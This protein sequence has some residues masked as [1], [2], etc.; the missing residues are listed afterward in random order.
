MDS[1]TDPATHRVVIHNDNQHSFPYVINVLSKTLAI[2]RTAA[3]QMAEEIHTKG[4]AAIPVDTLA[5]AEALRKKIFAY[6]RDALAPHSNGSLIVGIESRNDAGG[7]AVVSC[8]RVTTEGFIEMNSEAI[9]HF[10]AQDAAA[11]AAEARSMAA[12]VSQY[13]QQERS[14]VFHLVG[15]VLVILAVCAG[16]AFLL[17]AAADAVV[18][19]FHH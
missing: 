18:R 5:A 3:G 17:L 10:L 13:R 8:G 4:L 9:H 11:A 14:N 2:E 12:L 1:A 6:G 7:F 19:A 15:V 16:A